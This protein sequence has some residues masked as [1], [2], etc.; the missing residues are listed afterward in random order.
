MRGARRHLMGGVHLTFFLTGYPTTVSGPT[1]Y[2][3]NFA[4]STAFFST[5]NTFYSTGGQHLTDYPTQHATDYPTQ[6]ITARETQTLIGG[7]PVFFNTDVLTDGFTGVLTDGVTQVL[8]DDSHI[9]SLLTG[10][11]TGSVFNT[12][13]GTSNA[14]NFDA[15][16]DV[17]TWRET[18]WN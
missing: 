13:R 4:T 6:K 3:T 1:F 9:T 8:T 10:I 17:Q 2:D 11:T 5:F 15:L 12:S 18:T 14:T 7:E 16:T